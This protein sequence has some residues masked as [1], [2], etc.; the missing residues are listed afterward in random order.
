[1]QKAYARVGEDGVEYN[2]P[3][4]ADAPAG[5]LRIGL[6]GP[7]PTRRPLQLAQL[8]EAYKGR[9]ELVPIASDVPGARPPPSW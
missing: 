3:P 7:A 6:F 2:G 1:M 8:L 5:P 9:Y 4:L